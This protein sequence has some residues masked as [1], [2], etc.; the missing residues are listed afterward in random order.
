[1]KRIVPF[2]L[3][4]IISSMTLL[5]TPISVRPS[6]GNSFHITANETPEASLTIVP[7]GN[8]LLTEESLKTEGLEVA[9]WSLH[10]NTKE[11]MMKVQAGHLVS[12]ED[13]A[14]EIEYT[15]DFK[16][17]NTKTIP[18]TSGDAE[19]VFYSFIEEGETDSVMSIINQPVT[20][21]LADDVDI[22][23]NSYPFGFYRA[24]VKI[25]IEAGGEA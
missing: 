11:I 4:V 15:I 2:F 14:T 21:T 6:T 19:S 20:L 23:D 8:F 10:S 22:T 25:V 13:P 3:F 1:M 16:I 12:D 17:D 18:V 5:A 24:T 7:A 9:S